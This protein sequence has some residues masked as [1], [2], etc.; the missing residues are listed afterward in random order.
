MATL[1]PLLGLLSRQARHE[2]NCNSIVVSLRH[3]PFLYL[4]GGPFVGPISV[5]ASF[6]QN[7]WT[8][9]LPDSNLRRKLWFVVERVRVRVRDSHQL[10]TSSSCGW[11]RHPGAGLGLGLGPLAALHFVQILITQF[12]KCCTK[13]CLIAW[14]F[15]M[16]CFAFA[17]A[18]AF[19][20]AVVVIVIVSLLPSLFSL[21]H[22]P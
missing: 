9:F 17:V 1:L 21:L 11:S 4:E 16:K 22:S 13:F 19:A 15:L 18:F 8:S 12:G 7:V 3:L 2:S 5:S 14:K 10:S 20:F 6:K